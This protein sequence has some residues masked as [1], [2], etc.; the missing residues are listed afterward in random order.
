M[1]HPGSPAFRASINR[2]IASGRIMPGNLVPCP[3]AVTALSPAASSMPFPHC[4]GG[5]GATTGH[6]PSDRLQTFINHLGG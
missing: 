5:L 3:M 6:H 1:D 2:W 4:R